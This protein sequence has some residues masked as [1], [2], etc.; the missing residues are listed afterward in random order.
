[1]TQTRRQ[2]DSALFRDQRVVALACR[3][4]LLLSGWDM[5]GSRSAMTAR[6]SRCCTTTTQ[7]MQSG[8]PASIVLGTSSESCQK[9]CGRTNARS[10]NH[11]SANAAA[12]LSARCSLRGSAMNRC[13]QC[14]GPF[15]LVRHLHWGRQFC[16]KD[17]VA[18]W[19]EGMHLK[20]QAWWKWL[21][22]EPVSQ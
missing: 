8:M 7:P 11:P 12:C 4:L 3:S 22:G 5:A 16:S 19:L 9:R 6:T 18:A 15:G 2:R 10:T 21:Y 17:C 1:M 20:R 14:H 13:A